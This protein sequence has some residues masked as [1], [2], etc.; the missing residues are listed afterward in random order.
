MGLDSSLRKQILK[1]NR[2][3]ERYRIE[4]QDYSEFNTSE[5]QTAGVTK[6]SAEIIAGR[7]P[8][9]LDVFR[10]PSASMSARGFWRIS[11]PT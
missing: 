10:L 1:F 4:V 6:M 2:Q 5:D 7:V 3:S 9:I 11:T 8:D